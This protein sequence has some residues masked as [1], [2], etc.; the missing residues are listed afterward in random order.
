M[1]RSRLL[2]LVS[3][4]AL[5]LTACGS[6]GTAAQTEDSSPTSTTDGASEGVHIGA[7][8][9]GDIL[10][11]PDGNSLYV[12][13]ADSEGVSACT[14]ACLES[15]PA[16]SADAGVAPDLDQTMFGSI[17][18]DDGQEQM[19][20]NGMPLYY[21]AA[22]SGPGDTAGQGLNDSWFVVDPSG[23]KVS[24]EAA[25]TDDTVIDYGY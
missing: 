21:Y 2:V 24:V 20:V 4:V 25:D 8:E 11:G 5:T 17:T 12:F 18:R 14:G 6:P 15:W 10:V 22:D 13:T 1:T 9:H 7:S 23:V 19:T 3:A 16:L